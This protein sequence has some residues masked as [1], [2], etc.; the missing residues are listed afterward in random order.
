MLVYPVY[1][2]C[3]GKISSYF[4]FTAQYMSKQSC[5]PDI[6]NTTLLSCLQG[7]TH[8]LDCALP[9]CKLNQE[10]FTPEGECCPICQPHPP[11]DCSAVLCAVTL[12]D[13][14]KL[15]TPEGEC[16]LIRKPNLVVADRQDSIHLQEWLVYHRCRWVIDISIQIW[17]IHRGQ[18]SPGRMTL[19]PSIHATAVHHDSPLD[20]EA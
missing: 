2:D 20:D 12:R 4:N 5:M 7:N 13:N 9:G 1:R 18:H 11:P 19:M 8:W 6:K 17:L 16:C 14:S 10:F 3:H 15:V